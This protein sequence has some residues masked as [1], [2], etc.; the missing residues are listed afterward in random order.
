[1]GDV[2]VIEDGLGDD[3]VMRVHWVA[4][5]RGVLEVAKRQVTGTGK[6]P[7]TVEEDEVGMWH[8][9]GAWAHNGPVVFRYPPH[10]NDPSGQDWRCELWLQHVE[11]TLREAVKT[12]GSGYERVY[13]RL[14][15]FAFVSSI[16]R[17]AEDLM[18]LDGGLILIRPN[19]PIPRKCV[20]VG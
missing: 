15:L 13:G 12:A 6:V 18:V 20:A 9:R 2:M 4:A 8:L 1:M 14:P 3:G 5:A 16:P 19:F 10:P 17:E 11:G 7:V